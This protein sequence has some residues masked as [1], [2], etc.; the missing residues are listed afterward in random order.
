MNV[1]FSI[2]NEGQS[3]RAAFIRVCL[4]QTRA[5]L[6]GEKDSLSESLIIKA[7]TVAWASTG[8]QKTVRTQLDI[9]AQIIEPWV[10]RALQKSRS[11]YPRVPHI[12]S[13]HYTQQSA[14]KFNLRS[15]MKLQPKRKCTFN[16]ERT[17]IIAD[18]RRT[19]DAS[20]LKSPGRSRYTHT[21]RRED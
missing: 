17:I 3:A 5:V 11:N 12:L 2:N 8:Q 16:F 4:M 7:S 21:Y 9:S 20:K 14:N 6:F 15:K 18:P 19:C 1:N 10:T 13:T